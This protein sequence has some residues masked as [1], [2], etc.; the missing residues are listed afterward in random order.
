MA[1]MDRFWSKVERTDDCWLWTAHHAVYGS[2]WFEGRT[3]S[4]HRVAWKL[5]RGPIPVGM[6]VM[7]TCDTPTCVRPDHLRLGTNTENTRDMLAKGRAQTGPAHY[8]KRR[9]ELVLRGERHGQAR[10]TTDQVRDVRRRHETGTSM[11]RLAKEYGV[12]DT[13]IKHIVERRNWRHVA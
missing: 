1:A 7:H 5:T 10:F 12:S 9:P 3:Q 2:F 13:A 11:Y 4:A 8:S 6:L